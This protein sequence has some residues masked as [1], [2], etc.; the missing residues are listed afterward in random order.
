MAKN[1]DALLDALDAAERKIKMLQ[2]FIRDMDS[3]RR[4]WLTALD[5][6]VKEEERGSVNDTV[7]SIHTNARKGKAIVKAIR[8]DLREVERKADKAEAQDV[9]RRASS[10]TNQLDKADD[11]FDRMLDM[12]ASE[13]LKGGSD[14]IRRSFTWMPSFLG[15]GG[16][17]AN[18]VS[19]FLTWVQASRNRAKERKKIEESK[20]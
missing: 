13:L 16:L 3:R 6:G 1:A 15:L 5:Q 18:F 8:M 2:S 7:N 9:S 19:V 20:S 11:G 4:K 12:T 10:L 17:V 14:A